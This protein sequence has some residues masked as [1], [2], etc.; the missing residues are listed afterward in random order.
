[1][2]VLAASCRTSVGP[3]PAIAPIVAAT[4]EA[5]LEQLH[6]RAASFAGFRSLLRVKA[7]TGDET[8]NFRAQLVIPNRTDM[9]LIGYTPL[10][11]TA[12]TIKAS[13]DRV[14]YTNHLRGTS[15]QTSA[16]GLARS[17]AFY[18]ADLKP[19]EMAMLLSG[20]PPRRDLQYETTVTGLARATIGDVVVTFDPP[21]YPPQNVR[22]VRGS[23]SVEIEFLEIVAE[24]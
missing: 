20:L 15:V 7:V 14:S 16:E 3:G 2:S 12:V 8:Q 24:R 10:G 11:T 9:E 23:D 22:V 1:M 17:L 18:S 13:G 4:P 21:Q 5:A 19:A 6:G